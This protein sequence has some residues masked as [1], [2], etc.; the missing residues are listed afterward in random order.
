MND[1]VLLMGIFGVINIVLCWVTRCVCYAEGL[2]KRNSPWL[3]YAAFIICH[4][5]F[6][7][8]LAAYILILLG[9]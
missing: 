2:Y 7:A 5:G 8:G 9:H 4:T 6:L 1:C 3:L